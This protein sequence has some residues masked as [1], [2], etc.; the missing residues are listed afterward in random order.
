MSSHIPV[1]VGGVS[2]GMTNQLSSYLVEHILHISNMKAFVKIQKHC[3]NESFYATI[4]FG[5]A[6]T[7]GI[8]K[9][10]IVKVQLDGSR[11]VMEK[12]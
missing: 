12:A 7:I 10:D 5:I 9:G 6:K 11:V 2:E 3:H 8:G 1:T 4:P